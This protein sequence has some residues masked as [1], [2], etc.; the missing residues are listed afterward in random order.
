MKATKTIAEQGKTT[1]KRAMEIVQAAFPVFLSIWG[2]AQEEIKED[3]EV[4]ES[5]DKFEEARHE[6]M[7]AGLDV[8]KR[9]E[10]SREFKRHISEFFFLHFFVFNESSIYEL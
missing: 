3:E 7:T 10:K 5:I 6:V 8:Q 9:I 2:K 1:V 4:N